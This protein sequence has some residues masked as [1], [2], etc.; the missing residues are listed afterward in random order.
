VRGRT[1]CEA[2]TGK[3]TG[4]SVRKVRT[5]KSPPS[6]RSSIPLDCDIC[7]PSF[8]F[9]LLPVFRFWGHVE[10]C[11]SSTCRCCVFTLSVHQALYSH[12]AYVD[13]WPLPSL[14]RCLLWPCSRD[15]YHVS[16]ASDVQPISI[17][18]LIWWAH[19]RYWK[20][21]RSHCHDLI[22]VFTST[23][24]TEYSPLYNYQLYPTATHFLCF[25]HNAWEAFCGGALPNC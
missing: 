12:R 17:L 5:A 4:A 24:S 7:L 14:S 3:R 23:C 22:N 6:A 1:L 25:E 8:H 21:V 18:G 13:R 10:F 20:W 2:F 19:R 16:R 9:Q 11:A 15:S